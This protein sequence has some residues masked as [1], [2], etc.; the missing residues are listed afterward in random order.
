M[1]PT[2]AELLECAHVVDIP[3]RVPFRGLTRREAVLLRGPCGWAEFAP[4]AE[5]SDAEAAVWL[6]AAVEAGWN[7]PPT[8][9]R[10]SID[11]NATVPAVPAAR[12]ASVLQAFPGARTAKVKVAGAGQ[13]LAADTAR[14]AAV[15]QALGPGAAIR[16]DANGGWDL[17]QAR[18]A[19]R[20]LSAYELEYAEQPVASVEDLARLRVALARD[21][22]EVAVAADESV[23][24]AGDPIR[25]ARAGAADL[26][27][28][29]VAPLG[30][31]RRALSIV[32]DCGLPAVVSSALD[33]TVGIASGVR[34]AACLPTLPYAC[35]LGTMALFDGDVSRESLR[36]GGGS[37]T[38]EQ[39]RRGVATVDPELLARHAAGPIRTQWWRERLE[40]CAGIYLDETLGTR[41]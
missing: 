37:L 21:G 40:R 17:Q 23:R 15:R 9:V 11:V 18:S 20:A 24:R 4:F 19:L 8:P 3:L 1:V 35:G 38:L 29:K 41:S 5:Y 27:V 39:A 28:V 32:A 16:V 13:D 34:L 31:I 25:V 10:D 6:A 26:V 22:I 36:P 33:T 7:E 2:P 30:G 14:V 12:V